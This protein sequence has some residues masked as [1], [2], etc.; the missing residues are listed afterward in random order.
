MRLPLHQRSGKLG[1]LQ[2]MMDGR[3]RGVSAELHGACRV[4]QPGDRVDWMQRVQGG[5]QLH[6]EDA[7]VR[8]KVSCPLQ[9]CR[10]CMTSQV[11]QMRGRG[12]ADSPRC[13]AEG[14]AQGLVQSLTM[15]AGC[16]V[17]VCSVPSLSAV[18]QSLT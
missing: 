7:P 5:K 1:R 17:Q 16:G 11:E 8:L 6:K 2:L 3:D 13:A 9:A 15:S 10:V 18:G 12:S 14:R 4:V